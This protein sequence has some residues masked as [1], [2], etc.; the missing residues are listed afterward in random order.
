MTTR[1]CVGRKRIYALIIDG[2]M[3]HLFYKE[4][5]LK[6]YVIDM[7]IREYNIKTGF[8]VTNG[9][10]LAHNK[11][12]PLVDKDYIVSRQYISDSICK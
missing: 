9:R 5:E 1:R 8:V 2:K 12:F 10:K 3:K 4:N 6:N 11:K 7:S